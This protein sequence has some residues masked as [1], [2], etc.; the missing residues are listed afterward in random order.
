MVDRVVSI[1]FDSCGQCSRHVLVLE[2]EMKFLGMA[3]YK[4]A[5]QHAV[6]MAWFLKGFLPV[7]HNDTCGVDERCYT[8]SSRQ[9]LKS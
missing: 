4:L 2:C 9:L 1:Q 8:V 7:Q 3:I 6:F 5:A